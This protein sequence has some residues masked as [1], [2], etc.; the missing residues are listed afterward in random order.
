[1]RRFL[2]IVLLGV[3][4]GLLAAPGVAARTPAGFDTSAANVRFRSDVDTGERVFLRYA[5]RPNV[6][7]A[8]PGAASGPP[9]NVG[10]AFDITVDDYRVVL[11]RALDDLRVTSPDVQAVVDT[12]QEVEPVTLPDGGAIQ[13]DLEPIIGDLTANPPD[14]ESAIQRIEALLS[15]LARASDTTVTDDAG[16]SLRDVLA[17]DEFNAE[18]VDDPP[19][20]SERFW[21]WVWDGLRWAFGPIER[22]F[23]R[24]SGTGDGEGA[25]VFDIIVAA[26]GVAFIAGLLFF[27]VRTIRGSVGPRVTG[28]AA[29][30][31][32][33]TFSSI[34]ARADADRLAA[35]GN[36]RAALR[37][38]YLA[39]LLQL[40]EA[41][42]LRF[43]RS[44]TNR[45]VL[46]YT[47]EHGDRTL[48]DQLAPL[49]ERFDS[50]WYGGATCTADDYTQ[51][52]ALADGVGDRVLA[53]AAQVAA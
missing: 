3:L 9:T 40:E 6:R 27:V 28:T 4:G 29:E 52:A 50:V 22:L 23:N 34:A 42:R 48:R 47:V 53:A 10:V 5:A 30:R 36:Y 21:G 24:L 31:Q 35:D 20:W 11:E 43:D 26:L 25:S 8:T 45:E 41:G 32:K 15:T 12:L 51:F 18:P 38:R 13:P 46:T 37:A 39:T 2:V 7:P 14:I 49:V 44:L 33:Q 1:M 16:G 17:R 19:S